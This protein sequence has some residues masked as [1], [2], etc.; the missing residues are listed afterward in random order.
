MQSRQNMVS[1]G[2]AGRTVGRSFRWAL[3]GM[4]KA[5]LSPAWGVVFRD[6]AG[7]RKMVL[8]PALR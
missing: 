2:S 1:G 8:T 5:V 3:G 6:S 7:G 4:T